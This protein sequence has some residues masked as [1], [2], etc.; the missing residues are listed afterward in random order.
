ML[1]LEAHQRSLLAFFA[2]RRQAEQAAQEL[3]DNGFA[4]VQ[5]DQV[6]AGSGEAADRINNPITG[7]V[8]GLANMVLGTDLAG[9]DEAVLL[10]ADPNV[11]GMADGSRQETEPGRRVLVT[12]VAEEKEIPRAKAIINK[13]GGLF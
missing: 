12:V 6:E 5:V 4:T 3:R 10:A 7:D 1:Q 9:R 8:P 11:S 13:H 2:E